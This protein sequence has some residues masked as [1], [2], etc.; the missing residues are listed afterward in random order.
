MRYAWRVVRPVIKLAFLSFALLFSLALIGRLSVVLFAIGALT[1]RAL[2][3]RHRVR[4]IAPAWA[5][6]LALSV[7]PIDVTRDATFPDGVWVRPVVAGL[8]IGPIPREDGVPAIW[9]TGSCIVGLND[10][11][12]MI[13][14]GTGGSRHEMAARYEFQDDDFE[15]KEQID[16]AV[17]VAWQL[18]YTTG[19]FDSFDVYEVAFNEKGGCITLETVGRGKSFAIR[20]FHCKSPHV[21]EAVW[22]NGRWEEGLV[23]DLERVEWNGLFMARAGG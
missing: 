22:A 15:T 6:V 5:F 18:E 23:E 2:F 4:W 14:F 12:W 7:A 9:W 20:G 11:V 16:E 19:S 8:L 13:V 3:W 1:S 10:P 17:R 21:F